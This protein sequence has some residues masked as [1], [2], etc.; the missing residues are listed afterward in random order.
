M[1]TSFVFGIDNTSLSC[2]AYQSIKQTVPRDLKTLCASLSAYVR[3][4]PVST[5]A[6]VACAAAVTAAIA[7]QIY[8]Q[9]YNQLHPEEATHIRLNEYVSAVR[10]AKTFIPHEWFTPTENSKYAFFSF[11]RTKDPVDHCLIE[12]SKI[13]E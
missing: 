3:H 4:N 6:L 13:K 11:V 7:R 10:P 1:T 8:V 5:I 9:V 2:A 12:L